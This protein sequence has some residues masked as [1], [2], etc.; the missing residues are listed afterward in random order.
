M[1]EAGGA[2]PPWH[3]HSKM[4]PGKRR[5]RKGRQT[6]MEK[7]RLGILGCGYLGGIVADAWK[8]G[9]LEDY[10]LV[11]VTSRTPASAQS[12]AVSAT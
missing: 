11:G 1:V 8:Q 5:H 7:K 2:A 12:L 10:D 4:P 6:D 9:L 3:N